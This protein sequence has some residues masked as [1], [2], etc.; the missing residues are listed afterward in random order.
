MIGKLIVLASI[1]FSVFGNTVY[2]RPAPTPRVE[3]D[4]I[5]HIR[6]VITSRSLAP[7]MAK[8]QEWSQDSTGRDVTV[9]ISSPGG[10]VT[11]GTALINQMKQAQ[12]VGVQF[13]CYVLDM[14]ASMAFQI[15]THCDSRYSLDTSYL[16]WHGVRVG[17]M[18][19]VTE[20]AARS[21]MV[22]LRR[23]NDTITSQ[24]TDTMALS[25]KEIRKHFLAETLWSGK[26]LA[27][28]DSRFITA[29][30][31]FPEIQKNL[32]SAVQSSRGGG[33]F[34]VGDFIY[35]WSR[36]LPK[37]PVMAEGETK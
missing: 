11:S 15:L 32:G 20:E 35:I 25:S 23:F 4:R 13:H 9:V 16:L 19:I 36:Y 8:V 30:R 33:M 1:L 7:I 21:I 12:S 29:R 27:A 22:D 5:V 31:S 3:A 34:D 37:F 17:I 6:G 10:E 2:A 18:G 24:L 26:Q 28:A 14:A